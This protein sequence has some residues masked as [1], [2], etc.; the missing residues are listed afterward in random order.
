MK[1]IIREIKETGY[2]SDALVL[3]FCE[4]ER[5]IP[6]KGIDFALRGLI[7]RIISS[8]EFIG[9]RNQVTLVHTANMI[10]P[11]RI[12]LVGMGKEK[13]LTSEAVRQAGGKAMSYLAELGLKTISVSTDYLF[14]LRQSPIP[15]VEGSLLSRYH[16]KRYKEEDNAKGIESLI[17]LGKPEKALFD[18]LRW[19]EIVSSGVQLARDLINTPANDMTPSVLAKIAK[20]LAKGKVSVK[21]LNREDAEKEGM[22]AYLAVAKGSDEPP[23]FIVIKYDGADGPPIVFIGKSITFDSGGISIK[24]GEGM[25][26]MKY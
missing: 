19:I 21:I 10:K 16:F 23:K 17:L 13:N 15:F 1:V 20:T 8:G 7:T 3:P 14:S 5:P 11:E 6:Y 22:G 25:E 12:L 26:K 9:K 24:P 18:S 2:R 4:G